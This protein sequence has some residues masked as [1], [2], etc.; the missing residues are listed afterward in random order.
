MNKIDRIIQ[1]L[2]KETK[3]YLDPAMNYTEIYSDPYTVLIGC[4]ISLRT[5]DKVTMEASKK[6]FSLAKTPEDMVKLSVKQIENTIRP[7]NYY[8]TK[9][10][11]IKDISEFLLKNYNGRV[12][13]KIEDLLKLKGVG[14]K[15]ANIVL[16]H[17][18]NKNAIAVDTHVHRISN[19]LG[20][21]KTKTPKETE[22][23]LIR[24]LPKKHWKKYNTLL[25]VWGQNVCKPI[26][27]LCNSCPIYEYCERVGVKE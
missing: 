1:I 2:E 21:V 4:I 6:L 8:K 13:D 3:K 5:K 14:R 22:E 10:K 17:A 19:R 15:T 12:P 27:P 11:R 7:S 18:F 16:S 25:V 24:I 9:A 26:K 23:A 20:L